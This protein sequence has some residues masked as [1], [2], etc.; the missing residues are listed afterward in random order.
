VFLLISLLSPPV[1][2]AR[3]LPAVRNWIKEVRVRTWLE[4]GDTRVGEEGPNFEG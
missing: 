2:A 1:V 3:D 4:V